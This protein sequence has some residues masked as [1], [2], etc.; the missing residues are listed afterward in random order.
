MNMDMDMDTEHEMCLRVI[1]KIIVIALFERKVY[2]YRNVV[3]DVVTIAVKIGSV[4]KWLK[5]QP[6][7]EYER[8]FTTEDITDIMYIYKIDMKKFND[9]FEDFSNFRIK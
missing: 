8:V 1:A 2:H 3:D 4:T 6:F 5:E 7:A 9:E